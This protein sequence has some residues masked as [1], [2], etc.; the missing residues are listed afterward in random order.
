[1]DKTDYKALWLG[2]CQY[3]L[4]ATIANIILLVVACALC[5]AYSDDEIAD[6]IYKA[7]N[8]KVYP[9]GI[10]IKYKHTTSRQACI[11]TIRHA[12]RDWN[13]QGDF[14][15]FLG[16]RY[17]PVNCSNDNGTN[18]YWIKNVKFFLDRR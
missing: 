18:K 16:D 6:S 5:F 8:S 4:W 2:V 15:V 12:R 3:T 1:L 13:G 17:C 14:I 9:Y 7:E 10:L 11:N